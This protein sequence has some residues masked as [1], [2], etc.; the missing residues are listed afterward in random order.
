[1]WSR[2]AGR[3]TRKD[4]APSPD[5]R[6]HRVHGHPQFTGIGCGMR[7]IGK[8][9]CQRG[10]T[11]VECALAP[12]FQGFLFANTELPRPGPQRLCIRNIRPDR[13]RFH[14][15]RADDQFHRH[16]L[17]GLDALEQIAAPGFVM[18]NPGFDRIMI[19]AQCGVVKF[20]AP[21]VVAQRLHRG[22]LPCGPALMPKFQY[23]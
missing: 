16:I 3:E 2:F 8:L 7:P 13:G 12:R 17:P 10:E 6:Q 5:S 9:H 1:M 14:Q 15:L 20:S 18:I 23:H 22:F 21:A 11:F 4:L 19:L